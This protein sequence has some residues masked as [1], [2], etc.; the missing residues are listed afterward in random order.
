MY[1]EK[2]NKILTIS[3]SEMQRYLDLGYSIKDDAGNLISRAIPVDM[4]SMRIELNRLIKENE[5]LR[6]EIAE[7]KNSLSAPKKSEVK[8]VEKVVEADTEE[9]IEEAPK[10]KRTRKKSE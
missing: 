9:T 5:A 4:S 7:L 8:P 2:G 3:E 6:A 1:A 10:P